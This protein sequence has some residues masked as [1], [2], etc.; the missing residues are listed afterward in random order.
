MG[1]AWIL[2]VLAIILAIHTA[3]LTPSGDDIL[4]LKDK[5][6][7]TFFHLFAVFVTLI[8]MMYV[9]DTAESSTNETISKASG[10]IGLLV[11]AIVGYLYTMWRRKRLNI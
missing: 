9:M 7:E 10:G 3:M 4:T 2:F 5:L 6:V 8:L 11:A 1:L